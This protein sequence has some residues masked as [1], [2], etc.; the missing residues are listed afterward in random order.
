MNK[1]IDIESNEFWQILFDEACVEGNQAVRIEK[2]LDKI[3]IE[4]NEIKNKA[5]HK[6]IIELL[7]WKPKDESYKNLSDVCYEIAE[8][9]K[10]N[11]R[12]N[13]EINGD[14]KEKC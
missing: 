6:F 1:L 14:Y 2:E 4:E 9:L 7:N 11:S 13:Q 10:C 3:S 12:S 8:R 5:I